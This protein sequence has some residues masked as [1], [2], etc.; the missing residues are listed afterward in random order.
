M[1]K[2]TTPF[3]TSGYFGPGYFCNRQEEME[4]LVRNIKGGHS[5]TL[6]ALR[7]MGKT[8]L[9]HH[10]FNHLKSDYLGIY[11][12]ILPTESMHDLLNS[13]ATSVANLHVEE[14]KPGA[15]VWKFLKSLRPV[16]SYDALSGSPNLS[17]NLTP[18]EGLLTI[19]GIFGFLEK[20]SKPVILAIDEF[21]Q[22]LNYPEKKADA[23]LRSRIQ[24]L[25]NV[26]FIFSGSQQHLMNE[27]FTDPSRPFYRSTQF[28]KLDR[29]RRQQY[30]D[31]IA[32]KFEESAKKINTKNIESILDWTN[33]WTYYVQLLCNRVFLSSD[34]VVPPGLWKEEAMRLLK[35]Q[36][37]VFYAYRDVLTVPQWNLLKAMAREGYV[38]SPTSNELI[39]RYQLGNPSTVLRSLKSLL[40]KEIIY[41]EL[42]AEGKPYYGVYD[43]LFSRWIGN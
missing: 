36:E 42:D 39:T 32:A 28:L 26:L 2:P 25:K 22:I 4:V 17:F 31:F 35:E 43:V 40:K 24:S 21:Q 3:P 5:T 9:I 12:D 30:L 7:R 6:V 19:E 1:K 38:E 8:A 10:L 14:S 33:G 41:R 11:V 16:V 27:L 23:W 13:L 20:Q 18:E 15:K 37:Y 34:E 29:I